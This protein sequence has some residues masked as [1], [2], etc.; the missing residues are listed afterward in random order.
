MLVQTRAL[1]L[2]KWKCKGMHG[3]RESVNESA[4]STTSLDYVKFQVAIKLAASAA[5]RRGRASGRLDHCFV[6]HFSAAL[7]GK[8][9]SFSDPP[10]IRKAVIKSA[11][12]TASLEDFGAMIQAAV[13]AAPCLPQHRTKN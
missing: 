9:N 5:S 4:A 2:N 3:V 12:S 7:A 1:G 8:R 13:G 11:A 6:L 10:S